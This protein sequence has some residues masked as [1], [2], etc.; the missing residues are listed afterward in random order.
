MGKN[1]NP[2]TKYVGAEL[3]VFVG[4]EV[5]QVV[6]VGKLLKRAAKGRGYGKKTSR[7]KGKS[8][9]TKSFKGSL[10]NNPVGRIESFANISH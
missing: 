3:L 5:A 1:V 10:Q 7:Q 4:Q 2:A 8:L 6:S 9:K